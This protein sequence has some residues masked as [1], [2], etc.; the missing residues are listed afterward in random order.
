MSALFIIL[1]GLTVTLFSEKMLISTKCNAQ[2]D[3]KK[4]VTVSIENIFPW[5]HHLIL[6]FS[7]KRKIW[8]WIFSYSMDCK[9]QTST[10]IVER[11][12]NNLR[13]SRKCTTYIHQ[14]NSLTCTSFIPNYTEQCIFSCKYVLINVNIQYANHW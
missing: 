9:F 14:K 8:L 11:T 13:I 4:S 7:W 5:E 10:T 3:Q 1:V 2:L 12:K 6:D